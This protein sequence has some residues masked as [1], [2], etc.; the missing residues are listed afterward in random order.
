[1]ALIITDQSG[2]QYALTVNAADGSLVTT[3]TSN[4]T[5]STPDSSVYRTTLDMITRSLRLI[6]VVADKELPTTDEANDCLESFQDMIDAWN[7]DG[8]TVYS[9][10][11]A[12]F[13][14]TLGQ[15]AFTIGPGGNFDTNRPPKI[16][17]M[18]A[19]LLFLQ[20]IE[21]G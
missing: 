15:Q 19:I 11:S 12:D 2:N 6:N 10:G 13:P 5:P 20:P 1:M 3:A 21:S 4:V 8:L 18:S 7:A 14:L 16:V 17:G 9:I